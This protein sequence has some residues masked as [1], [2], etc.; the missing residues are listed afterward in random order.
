MQNSVAAAISAQV[1]A[2]QSVKASIFFVGW[3][4]AFHF[5]LR[6]TLHI[7]LGSTD[8][9]SREDMSEGDGQHQLPLEQ[10]RWRRWR[11]R[12]PARL[13]LRPSSLT[14]LRSEWNI[15]SNPQEGK[16]SLPF[17]APEIR[18]KCLM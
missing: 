10:A 9:R 14:R 12:R 6:D 7:R 4:D 2:D 1:S 15:Y 17:C 16:K 18:A 13:R 5:A 8:S 3:R 11:R